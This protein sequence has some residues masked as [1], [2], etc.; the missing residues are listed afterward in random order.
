MTN[1]EANKNEGK[2][3]SSSSSSERANEKI[4]PLGESFVMG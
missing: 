2:S 4:V 3:S 1:P